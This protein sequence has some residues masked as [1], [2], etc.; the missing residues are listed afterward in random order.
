MKD[1]AAD[2][3]AAANALV[4]PSMTADNNNTFFTKTSVSDVVL[5]AM[6]MPSQNESIHFEIQATPFCRQLSVTLFIN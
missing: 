2:F 1:V 4:E 6:D 3:V 5:K